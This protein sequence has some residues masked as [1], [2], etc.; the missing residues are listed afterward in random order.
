MLFR[1]YTGVVVAATAGPCS[2]GT[3][4]IWDAEGPHKTGVGFVN[5]ETKRGG[6][7]VFG[8]TDGT[9]GPYAYIGLGKH[10]AVG[11]GA[12]VQIRKFEDIGSWWW[13]AARGR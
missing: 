10:F 5:F 4:T 6:F 8:E 1:S 12:E 3:E 7:G 11:C 13:R 2:G 9:Y